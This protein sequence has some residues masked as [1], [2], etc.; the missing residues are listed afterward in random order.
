[1]PEPV[2]GG[3]PP[4]GPSN[5]YTPHDGAI[6]NPTY[7]RPNG[8]R[9]I[10]P[11]NGYTPHDGAI[12]NPTYE[13]PNGYRPYDP[14]GPADSPEKLGGPPGGRPQYPGPFDRPR[15]H[16]APTDD[17]AW[18][19][20]PGSPYLTYDGPEEYDPNLDQRLGNFVPP[21]KT[22]PNWIAQN[23]AQVRA[24]GMF[25]DPSEWST[26]RV[27][28]SFDNGAGADGADRPGMNWRES[29]RDAKDAGFDVNPDGPAAD[30]STGADRPGMDWRRERRD[31]KGA[32]Y[33]VTP[34]AD[35]ADRPGKEWRGERR[36]AKKAGF[37]VNPD[38]PAADGS[39]G[40][41]RPGMEYRR[42]RRAWRR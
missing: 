40:A 14:E 32:G 29:R 11:S 1:M 25:G 17:S 37:D 16:Y 24:Q 13:R 41:D 22:D 42:T 28:D 19:T 20:N 15:Q 35:G 21:D 26:M 39:T 31:A 36:D 27:Q 8:Y 10:G 30:G 9:P 7:E 33:D 34:G 5:G 38:G 18:L 6:G 4:I 23:D 2:P 3:N 12:G